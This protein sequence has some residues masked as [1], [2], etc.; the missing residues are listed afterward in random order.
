M[1]GLST[2]LI[3]PYNFS[4]YLSGEFVPS[5]VLQLSNFKL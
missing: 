4:I 3:L 1:F 2:K 5:I